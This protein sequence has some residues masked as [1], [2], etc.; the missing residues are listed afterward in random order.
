M[1]PTRRAYFELHIAVFLFGFTAILGKIISVPETVLVWWRVFFTVISLLL[2]VD[3]AR[4]Y[5]TLPRKTFFQFLAIGILVA[6][7]WVTFFGA[8]KYANVSICLICMAT[9]S[10]FTALLEPLI[11]KQKV[12]WFELG[13][14]LLIIPGMMLV[15]KNTDSF[16]YVGIIMGLISA[17]LAALFSTL[18]KKLIEETSP[19]T[20]T[21]LEIGGALLF[22]TLI[23]PI[24]LYFEP[25]VQLMP[26]G[27]DW[28]YLV[29]LA[30]LCTTFAYVLSLRALQHITAFA[31]N[32][33]VN[34]EPVYGIIL[35]IV[36]LQENKELD[37]GFYLGVLV[38]LAA[39]FAYPLLKRFN[40]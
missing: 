7:H 25:T 2:L 5:R 12:K 35:A 40:K 4:I 26:V 37:S 15:V 33:T 38:I 31:A 19:L 39:I 18:N 27:M 9:V 29:V 24:Y 16:M 23:M 28:V 17:F 13:L 36:L 30:L 1:N 3:V 20:I 32:L 8:A 11:M 22:L 34:L 14:G 21:F 6:I 10:F